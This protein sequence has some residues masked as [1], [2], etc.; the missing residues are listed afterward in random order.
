MLLA[1]AVANCGSAPASAQSGADK[2]VL[3]RHAEYGDGPNDEFGPSLSEPGRRRAQALAAMMQGAG[4]TAI[5]T[6]RYRRTRETAQ[7]L[8]TAIGVAPLVIPDDDVGRHVEAHV[9]AVR[10][11]SG[12][13]L[14]VGHSDTIPIIIRALGGPRLGT[15]CADVFDRMFTLVS[16]RGAMTLTRS[17]YGEPSQ[18]DGPNCP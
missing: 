17:H 12:S 8:A 16:D 9:Q 4:V 18:R 6:S 10:R 7:P 2:V 1:S 11:G 15:L 5:L 3:V 13:V 14:I